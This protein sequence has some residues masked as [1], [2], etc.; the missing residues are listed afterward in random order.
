MGRIVHHTMTDE[1]LERLTLHAMDLLDPAEAAELEEHLRDGCEFCR[2]QLLGFHDTY[3]AIA[4][5]VP[6]SAPDPHLRDRILDR[7]GSVSG[8]EETSS[9]PDAEAQVWKTWTQTP[10]A[11]VHVVRR[12]EEHWENVRPGIWAK[13]LYVDSE[14][15]TVTMLVRMDPG[16]SY[17]PHRHGGPEQCYVL[18]GDLRDGDLL[19][20]AGDFQCAASG[21]VHGAQSTTGGC[22]L[23][24]VSS[25]HDE[26]L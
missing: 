23:L 21:S 22:L 12:S 2:E 9:N 16:A 3:A 4:Y 7:L 25:L 19:V 5:S 24:I 14:R 6:L 26:L 17:I 11:E 15:D 20:T 10:Q 13:Q 18:E 1:L 8:D